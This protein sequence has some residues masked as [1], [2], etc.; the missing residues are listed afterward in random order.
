MFAFLE[1][2]HDIFCILWKKVGSRVILVGIICKLYTRTLPFPFS[3]TWLKWFY[4]LDHPS[5]CVVGEA[6]GYRP[7]YQ[8]VCNECDRLGWEFG[9]SFL[10][11]SRQGI[12]RNVEAFLNHWNEGPEI[13]YDWND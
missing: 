1:V 5:K 3:L 12:Q 6:H 13:P 2:L 4:E 10:S 7:T 11:H 9:G 8:K